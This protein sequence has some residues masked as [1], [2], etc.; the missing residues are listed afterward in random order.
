[1]LGG[2]GD[3]MYQTGMIDELQRDYVDQQTSLGMKLIQQQKWMKAFEV[4]SYLTAS[5][6]LL[7]DIIFPTALFFFVKFLSF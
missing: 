5:T 7:L 4:N 1:M 3:F 6:L 2:Y